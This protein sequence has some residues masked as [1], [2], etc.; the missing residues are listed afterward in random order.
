M[1]SIEEWHQR[2]M[3][4]ARWTTSVRRFLFEKAEI[5]SAKSVLEVGSGTGA[6]LEGL[7]AQTNARLVGID[8]NLPALRFSQ[9]R[10]PALQQISGLAERLP[11][12]DHAFSISCCHFFLLW[13]K[14]PL[15][16]LL[17][18]KR[19]TRIGGA[20]LALAE[21]DYGGRI[22]YPEPLAE[23]GSNQAQSL[24]HQ[25]AD[26]FVGRKLKGLFHRAGLHNIEVGV[27]DGQWAGQPT[28]QDQASEWKILEDDLQDTFPPSR[29]AE[30]KE[31]DR[32]AWQT[33]ERVLFVP[34][35]FAFGRV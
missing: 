26:P 31:I 22:D 9:G 33:G 34:T 16:A 10:N 6:I 12:A 11:A 24:I 8:L 15:A 23:L 32:Q 5:S 17:E 1:L 13:A 21:P 14:D 35:F 19:V 3:E 27:L 30:L 2:Y 18:M 20:I 25:G 4:Q 29:L 7:A 28:N